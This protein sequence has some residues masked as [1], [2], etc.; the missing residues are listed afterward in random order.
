MNRLCAQHLNNFSFPRPEEWGPC[1]PA[2]SDPHF[3][4]LIIIVTAQQLTSVVLYRTHVNVNT[5]NLSDCLSLSAEES[6]FADFSAS[7]SVLPH[8]LS[9]F[10]PAVS[11]GSRD[12]ES[13]CVHRKSQ[14]AHA[15]ICRIDRYCPVL[16]GYF[17]YST[18]PIY[19]TS[20]LG[21]LIPSGV[22]LFS[23]SAATMRGRASELPLSVWASCV[24]LSASR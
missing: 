20:T 14:A 18:P 15:C 4:S 24:F 2:G 17:I 19:G 5:L 6:V 11:Y 9:D 16:D 22:W 23:S 1:R 10:M 21:S 8:S 7:E 12:T 3:V 13:G